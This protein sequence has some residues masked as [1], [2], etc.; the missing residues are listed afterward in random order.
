MFPIYATIISNCGGSSLIPY[1]VQ[2]QISQQMATLNM[3]EH[4]LEIN[5][6]HLRQL[7]QLVTAP[8]IPQILFENEP[9]FESIDKVQYQRLPDGGYLCLKAGCLEKLKSRFSLKRHMKK[10]AENSY[11][12]PFP[13]CNKK[14]PEN[15]FPSI[16]QRHMRCHTGEK[17][18]NCRFPNCKK[19]FADATGVKRHEM[20]H[21]GE[22]PFPCTIENCN[23]RF[24]RGS[25]LKQHIASCHNIV[26]NTEVASYIQTPTV[27]NERFKCGNSNGRE[28]PLP[29]NNQS[30]NSLKHPAIL[31]DSSAFTVVK[32]VPN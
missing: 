28:S 25:T 10:H 2:Q 12:C 1:Y 23:R 19:A 29:G 30:K 11:T 26:G 14:F 18:F 3:L 4:Q 5:R 24:S 31:S 17:P 13:G 22:K 27:T 20:T 32:V 6:L 16:L 21:T 8:A 9:S 15:P 7:Q